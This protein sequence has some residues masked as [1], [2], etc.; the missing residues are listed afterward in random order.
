VLSSQPLTLQKLDCQLLG[1]LNFL[2]KTVNPAVDDWQFEDDH[3]GFFIVR[4]PASGES[5]GR[6]ST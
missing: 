6:W 3:E 2:I 1:S 5:G 4:V